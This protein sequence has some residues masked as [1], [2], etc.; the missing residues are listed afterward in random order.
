MSIEV[1]AAVKDERWN[2]LF[3]LWCTKNFM[4]ISF[5]TLFSTTMLIVNDGEKNNK[6]IWKWQVDSHNLSCMIVVV[7]VIVLK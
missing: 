5:I 6:F 4:T 2:I 7:K 1:K 3:L